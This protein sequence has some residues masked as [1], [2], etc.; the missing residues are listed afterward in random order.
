M[1]LEIVSKSIVALDAYANMLRAQISTCSQ[2]FTFIS[3]IAFELHELKFVT[4]YGK[5]V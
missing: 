4:I 5:P 2:N 1:S 3:E